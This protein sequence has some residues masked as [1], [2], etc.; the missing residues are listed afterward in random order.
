MQ[1]RRHQKGQLIQTETGYAVRFYESGEGHRRRVQ[2]WLGDFKQLPN[3]TAAK[4]AMDAVLFTVNQ[5]PTAN[6][7]PN[8]TTFRVFAQRWLTDC[9]HRKQKPVKPSVRSNWDGILTN[10][11]NPMIGEIPLAECGNRIMRSIVERLTKKRLS[12]ATI[13]NITLVVKLVRASAINEDGDQIFPIKWNSRF[14]DA[15]MVDTTK[16]HKPAFTGEQVTKIVQAA[17]GRLRM[18]AVLLAASG[19]RIGELL[20]LEC[21]HVGE[22]SIEVGQAVW[23]GK[24]GTPKTQNAYRVVDLHPDVADLLRKYIG[25]RKKGFVFRTSSGNT[26]SP[27]NLQRRELNPILDSLKIAR[28]GFHSFRRFRN[29]HLRQQHCPPG[30]LTFWMGHADPSMSS[31]Y[32][33]S[34]EDVQFRRDVAK[35]MGLGFQ[36]PTATL[37]GAIGRQEKEVETEAVPCQSR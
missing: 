31:H 17:S 22:S 14:I 24:V 21:R 29:T 2:T 5:N 25:D 28:S 1:R 23:G 36:L 12:P 37:T 33:R 32:D 8:T 11:L 16:Q 7:Q 13:K 19:L 4:N 6:P 10:H 34:R 15:P 18:A 30:I 20:A 26:L 3:P 9:E 35:A 27:S